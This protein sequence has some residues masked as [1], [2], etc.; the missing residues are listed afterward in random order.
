[1]L[2]PTVIRIPIIPAVAQMVRSSSEAP[3]VEEASVH[4]LA[5]Q[6]PHRSCVRV[7][8]DRLRAVGRVAD[9]VQPRRDVG[10]RLIPGRLDERA[11][12]LRADAAQWP[13]HTL[14]MMRALRIAIHLG[15]QEALGD[16]MVGVPL[17]TRDTTV[18]DRDQ[19]RT[20]IRAIV[21]ARATH[22]G[23]TA[24]VGRV[25]DHG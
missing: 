17:H 8:E 16:R 13:Q 6:D 1:M 5:L 23:G 20:R 15:A 19:H 21:R 22:D 18:R 10:E 25:T 3:S 2:A 7:R 11:A 4:R 9:C 24:L 12:S 14:R